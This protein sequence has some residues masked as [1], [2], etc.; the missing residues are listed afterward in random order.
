M[1]TDFLVLLTARLSHHYDDTVVAA[2][3]VCCLSTVSV[4]VAILVCRRDRSKRTR[5]RCQQTG[6]WLRAPLFLLFS[7]FSVSLSL[8]FLSVSS[9]LGAPAASSARGEDLPQAEE[10]EQLPPG[11]LSVI[12]RMFHRSGRCRVFFVTK[13]DCSHRRTTLRYRGSEVFRRIPFNESS[14]GPAGTTTSI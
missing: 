10:E 4:I 12:H 8:C 7:C 2:H 14:M 9:L 11:S 1:I 13:R 6:R 3:V 5:K